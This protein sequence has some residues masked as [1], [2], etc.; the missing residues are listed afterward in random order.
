MTQMGVFATVVLAGVLV[1]LVMQV[2]ALRWVLLALILN[3]FAPYDDDADAEV[4]GRVPGTDW[5][6]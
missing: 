4:E 6:A 5:P 3:P 1:A 2:W